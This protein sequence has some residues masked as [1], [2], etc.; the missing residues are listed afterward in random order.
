MCEAPARVWD[1]VDKGFIRVGYDADL[2]L[3]DL[4]QQHTIR[5]ANQLTKSGW[6]PWDGTRLTACRSELG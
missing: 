6:S 3:V 1:I 4:N 5:N 2:V